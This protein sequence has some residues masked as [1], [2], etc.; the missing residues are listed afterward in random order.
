[1]AQ[2]GA[3]PDQYV[4]VVT[5]LEIYPNDKVII[6]GFSSYISLISTNGRMIELENG[7]VYHVKTLLSN[8]SGESPF[9]AKHYLDVLTQNTISVKDSVDRYESFITSTQRSSTLTKIEISGPQATKIQN[10]KTKDQFRFD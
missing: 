9:L 5:G 1:M 7:G 3:N 6:T 8:S 10:E 2:R 4:R